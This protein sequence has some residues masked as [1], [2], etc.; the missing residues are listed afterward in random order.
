MKSIFAENQLYDAWLQNTSEGLMLCRGNEILYMNNQ[1]R[2]L[3]C[4]DGD[5]HSAA[6]DEMFEADKRDRLFQGEAITCFREKITLKITAVSENGYCL[7][8]IQDLTIVEELRRKSNEIKQLN[9]ELQTVYEQYADDTIF[10]T[11]GNGK[12][13][14]TGAM[15]SVN[16]GVSADY[17]GRQNVYDLEKEKVFIHRSPSDFWK[18]VSRKLS[19]RLRRQ[20]G[21]SSP[22]ERRSSMKKARSPR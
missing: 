2:Q 22:S 1:C 10:I 15:V 14:F 19:S 11:D 18:A 6:L 20:A 7:F 4:P 3:L 16:C 5:S 8:I 12:V 13:E 17:I 9:K 21:N